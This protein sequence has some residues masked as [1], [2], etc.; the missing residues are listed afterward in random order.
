MAC[1]IVDK[2]QVQP[3]PVTVV[4]TAS[5]KNSLIAQWL[6]VNGEL[7]CKWTTQELSASPKLLE[8]SISQLEAT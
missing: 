8:T 2:S 1:A 5:R 6:T 3:T 7:V 4:S